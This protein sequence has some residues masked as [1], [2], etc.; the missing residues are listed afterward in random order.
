LGKPGIEIK[1]PNFGDRQ[2]RTLVSDYTGTLSCGGILVKGVSERLFRLLH[3]V[4]IHIITADSFGTADEQLAGIVKPRKLVEREHD[5]EKE[6]IVRGLDPKHVV[7][8]GNGNN[9]RLML[10]AVK[11]AGGLAVAIDNGEGCAFD[12]LKNCDVFIVGAINALDLLL[13]PTRVKA[14]LRF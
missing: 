2:I 8:F 13:D 12:T 5:R 4:D 9:D 11:E 14:T 6:A 3:L 10:Q 7:G 1:I